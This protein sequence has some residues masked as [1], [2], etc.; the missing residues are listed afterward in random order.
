MREVFRVLFYFVLLRS[1]S[2]LA[3][4]RSFAH[5]VSSLV[6][7]VACETAT[8]TGM[9]MVFGEI[10]TKPRLTTRL[11]CARCAT[12]SAS[13]P[14]LSASTATAASSSSSASPRDQE[15]LHGKGTKALEEIAG[16][17][18]IMFGYATDEPRRTSGARHAP[19]SPTP[20]L[21]PHEV[22]NG[23]CW[24]RPDGKTRVTIDTRTRAAPAPQRTPCSSPPARRDC[25]QCQDC[26]IPRTR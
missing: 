6:S 15:R 20:R 13:P 24:V 9:V 11:S 19:I 1:G 14:R 21:P 26:G 17:Q 16:D 5:L 18:G 23:T 22:L 25:E 8:K 12:T 4:I 7:Q 2:T 10:T 3:V